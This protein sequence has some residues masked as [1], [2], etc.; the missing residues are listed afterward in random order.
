MEMHKFI[1]ECENNIWVD[2]MKKNTRI[3]FT[4]NTAMWYRIPFFRELSTLYNLDLVFTHINVINSIYDE[5]CDEKIEGL[6][7][8]NYTIL[9]NRFGFAVGLTKKLLEKHDVIIGGS[10]D[11]PQELMESILTLIIAKIKRQR[12]IIWREDWD[13]PRKATLKEKGLNKIIKILCR[14]ADKILVPGSLHKEYFKDKIGVKEDNIIIMPNVS[15]IK[16]KHIKAD[17]TTKNILYVGRLIKRKGVNYLLDA[18]KNLEI[19]D[20]KLII[21]GNGPEEEKLKKQVK[22]ENIENVKF[23]GKISNQELE[24]YY[25]KA[26]V[27]VIPS[28]NHEMGDPWVFVLNEAM[29]YSKPVIA[30]TAVGAAPDMIKGNG[31]IVEEKNSAQIT[32][33]LYEILSNPK[34]EEE[35]CQKSVSIIEEEF[36]YKNMIKGFNKAIKKE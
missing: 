14:N 26:N 25:S 30:T 18:Y 20:K 24:E 5:D 28:I 32:E 29:S 31:F 9:S 15:N 17:T 23:T 13:W 7:G 11:T 35:M 2:L 6:D 8:V 1:D 33:K 21:T 4:H 12:L 36:Q 27:V 22:T 19:K 34:L 16:T 3:L 10:W